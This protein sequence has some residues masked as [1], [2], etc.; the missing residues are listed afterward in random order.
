VTTAFGGGG[1][2]EPGT[3]SPVVLYNLVL[4]AHLFGAFILVSG[5]AIAIVGLETA[6]R[7]DNCTE[8][9]VLLDIGRVGALL[10]MAG[11]I[12]VAGF[13]F[14]LVSL[15]KWGYGTPWVVSGI[16]LLSIVL[17][18]GAIGGQRPKKARLLATR[19]AEAGCAPSDELRVML[20]DRVTIVLN[21]LSFAAVLGIIVVMVMKPG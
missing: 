12:L 1:A 17:I 16:S 21:Y 4:C 14:W 2:Q 19:L 9:A 15:G 10:L 6:S 18:L 13:G 8:V 20:N 7:R 5:M 11:T 3:M